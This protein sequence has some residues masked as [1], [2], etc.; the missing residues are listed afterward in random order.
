MADKPERMCPFK[1]EALMS[2]GD[3]FNVPVVARNKACICIRE[4]CMHYKIF[5]INDDNRCHR[6]K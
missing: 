2:S 4:E 1:I 3:F 6:T 5:G